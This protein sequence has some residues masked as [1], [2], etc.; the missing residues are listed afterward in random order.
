MQ[1]YCNKEFHTYISNLSLNE[2]TNYS[3][4]KATKRLKRLAISLPEIKK[5]DSTWAKSTLKKAVLFTEHLQNTFKFNSTNT[6][7]TI[8]SEILLTMTETDHTEHIT[9][10]AG[11][12]VKKTYRRHPKQRLLMLS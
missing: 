10:T 4:W 9:G 6:S 2:D 1:N 11:K 7:T 8:S 5:T 3:F 12:K